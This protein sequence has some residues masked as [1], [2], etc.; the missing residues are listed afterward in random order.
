MN[1]GSCKS[2]MYPEDPTQPFYLNGRYLPPICRTCPQYAEEP[3][4]IEEQ[5]KTTVVIHRSA[6][7]EAQRISQLEGKTN[8]LDKK[9]NEH[10]DASKKKGRYKEYI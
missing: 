9:F 4:P 8:Y 2:R 7:K 10:L 6:A 1:C 3:L 5:P